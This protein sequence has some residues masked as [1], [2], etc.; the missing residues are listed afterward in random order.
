[1]LTTLGTVYRES[2]RIPAKLVLAGSAC[3]VVA[4]GILLL[5][6]FLVNFGDL[7]KY[8]DAKKEFP[9]TVIEAVLRAKGIVVSGLL[10]LVALL[11]LLIS[12]GI[13]VLS[14]QKS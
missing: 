6:H 4:E 11:C 3:A 9:S 1:V 5:N 10:S 7:S 12:L 13:I 2:H 14:E 8:D